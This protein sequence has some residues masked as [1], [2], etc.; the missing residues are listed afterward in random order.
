MKSVTNKYNK[1]VEDTLNRLCLKHNQEKTE[2]LKKYI[3]TDLNVLG[4]I[5]KDQLSICKKGF[6]FYS[7][8]REESFYT[9][10][11]IYKTSSCF[12]VKN[13][14]FIYLEIHYKNIPLKTQLKL[15]PQWAKYVDNWAHSDTLSKYITRLVENKDTQQPILSIIK[16]WNASKNLWE[17]RQSLI[18][19]FY[20]SRTKKSHVE[21]GLAKQLLL[22]L[23]NDKEYFVQ[24]AVGW[25]LRECYNV[26][27]KLTY[28]FIESQLTH[29]NPVAFTTS[30]E[31]MT[32]KEKT[33]LKL[34]RKKQ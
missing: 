28:Q 33:A 22:P 14:A 1:E 13:L 31:K 2:K 17:R 3:G 15:L 12:E 27:P 4:I 34:K 20:Y 23:L 5:T 10:H 18:G 9:Y 6:S 16:K 25:T 29:I 21:F 30:I 19:L 7:E 8:H 26:Y 24:K 32:E 11:E